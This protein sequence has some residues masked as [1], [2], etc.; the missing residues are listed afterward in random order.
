MSW[1]KN[2]LLVITSIVLSLFALE[3]G[4]G[5]IY[6]E[7]VGNQ[8]NLRDHSD[9]FLPRHVAGTHV[10]AIRNNV[11]TFDED[12]MRL[13]PNQCASANA[14]NVLIVGDSN[15]AGLF[16]SDSEALGAQI[17][18]KALESDQCIK[19][20]SFGVSGFGPD[21][22]LFAIA[23]ITKDSAYD[24]VVFHLF[25]DN[26]LGDL[27][28]NNY[29]ADDVL[30]N[31]G[32][33]FPERPILER[34]VSFKAIRKFIYS[35]GLNIN[36]Y[37]SA[38]ASTPFDNT[39]ISIMHPNE[40]SFAVGSSIR[41]QLD[42]EAN[43]RSQ[44]QIYMGDRYDIEF[45]CNSNAEATQYV[46]R[47]FNRIVLDANELAAARDFNLVYLVQPSEDD[48]TN[49]H[50]GRVYKG[51]DQY[52]PENLSQFFV[53]ALGDLDYINLYET[54][55]NCNACYFT[56]EE[57]GGDNHWSPYGVGLAASELVQFISETQKR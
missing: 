53:N 32:Y 35:L 47:Y 20:D 10:G 41:A 31:S 44:R 17:T 13:N 48:V 1:I 26:D 43:R 51:C 25:A 30:I 19:V 21:Q 5:L 46:T 4:L 2:L 33:C 37:G 45:A 28:R 16:L 54:F 12:G 3:F 18:A 36:L 49:N 15:I 22:S 55:L 42:W 6:P 39:C 11:A 38:V 7:K 8:Q 50:K 52:S 29:F 34:F 14:I 23:E 40:E 57:L 9:S 27:I 56:E 24:Y